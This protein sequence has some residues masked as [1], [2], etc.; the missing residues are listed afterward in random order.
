MFLHRGAILR[1]CIKKKRIVSPTRTS[2]VQQAHIIYNF[3]NT[4]EKLCRTIATKH[5]KNM[6]DSVFNAFPENGTLVLKHVAVGTY[7]K[8]FIICF[9]AF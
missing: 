4:M 5:V 8:C 3:K 1:E 7:M 9:I 6:L 2:D